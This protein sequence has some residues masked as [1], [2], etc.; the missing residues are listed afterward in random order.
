MPPSGSV[1]RQISV[2]VSRSRRRTSLARAMSIRQ[3]T[4]KLNTTATAVIS[5]VTVSAE[6]PGE[7]AERAVSLEGR[8]LPVLARVGVQ[9]LLG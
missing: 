4:S 3:H 2:Q 6:V 1:T 5:A 8:N 9:R 7:E